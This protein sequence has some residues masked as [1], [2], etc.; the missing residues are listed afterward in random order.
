MEASLSENYHGFLS[1]DDYLKGIRINVEG[2]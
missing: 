2:P 1:Q